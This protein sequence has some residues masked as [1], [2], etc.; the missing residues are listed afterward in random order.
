MDE[1]KIKKAQGNLG[2]GSWKGAGE[3]PCFAEKRWREREQ[4]ACLPPSLPLAVDRTLDSFTLD[5]IH[6]SSSLYLSI[7]LSLSL[8]LYKLGYIASGPTSNV[9][10]NLTFVTCPLILTYFDPNHMI[11]TPTLAIGS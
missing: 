4:G 5:S 3:A 7:S 2:E 10:F 9:T 11:G 6:G 8:Y 1:K